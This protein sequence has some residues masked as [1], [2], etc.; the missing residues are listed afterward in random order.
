[1]N[2]IYILDNFNITLSVPTY[3]YVV[4]LYSSSLNGTYCTSCL[5]TVH[6]VLSTNTNYSSTQ[7]Y[8]LILTLPI[9]Q[10]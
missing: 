6:L 4:Q 5:M 7:T 8:I 1:M 10:Y 2:E 3:R 9:L